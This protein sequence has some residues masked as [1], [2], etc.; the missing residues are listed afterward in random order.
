VARDDTRR[1]GGHLWRA[2]AVVVVT[3]VIA[4]S[5]LAD[6]TTTL[7]KDIY[8]GS[9]SSFPGALRNVAG[10]AFFGATDPAHGEEL[11]KATP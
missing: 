5:A 2:L 4:T 7:V 3:L 6:T 1:M 10:K 9:G 11:W 8:P